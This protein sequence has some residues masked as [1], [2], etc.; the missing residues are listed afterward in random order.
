MKHLIL[1]FAIS[2]L[3]SSLIGEEAAPTA[4][5]QQVLTEAQ[6][7]IRSEA[8]MVAVADPVSNAS[9]NQALSND[10][11]DDLKCILHKMFLADNC[12]PLLTMMAGEAITESQKSIESQD[13]IQKFRQSFSD[14]KVLS[15]FCA[16]YDGV[17]S[18]KE[19][20]QLREIHE[21]PVYEKFSKQGVKIFQANFATLKE[22]FKELAFA[23]GQEIA[24][25]NHVVQITSDNFQKQIKESKKPVILDV[26]AT[27]CG[28]CR[29][30]EPTFRELGA[31]YKDQIVFAKINYDESPEIVEKYNVT[32]LPTFI[33]L[34]PGDATPAMKLTGGMSKAEFESQIAQ[35]LG[36]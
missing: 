10:R 7:E 6:S 27:W 18:D 15:R 29:G 26:Y 21:S 2:F 36:K 23:N 13:L 1:V 32:L 9:E 22:T 30:M 14:E 8:Q 19:I 34:R 24:V 5:V 25:I 33:F 3:A 20:H 11:R 12:E 16:P 35:F 17:F 4:E 31:Q 28:A